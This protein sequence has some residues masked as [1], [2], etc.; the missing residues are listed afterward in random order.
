[1]NK[2]EIKKYDE[3]NFIYFVSINEIIQN[4]NK[5][6]INFENYSH[7]LFKFS[8]INSSKWNQ[9]VKDVETL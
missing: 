9:N 4:I 3:N 8:K 2:N 7:Q 6:N 1:M 5:E